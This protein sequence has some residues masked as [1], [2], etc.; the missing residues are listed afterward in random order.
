MLKQN[1]IRQDGLEVL[2]LSL[3]GYLS[4]LGFGGFGKVATNMSNLA[5]SVQSLQELV[6]SKFI[7]GVPC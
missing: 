6:P 4:L 3:W 5:F 2:S 7:G 1:A